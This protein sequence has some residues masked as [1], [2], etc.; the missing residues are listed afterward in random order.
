MRKNLF[1]SDPGE[2]I[3]HL[4]LRDISDNDLNGALI[5][6][7]EEQVL[8]E[9]VFTVEVVQENQEDSLMEVPETEERDINPNVVKKRKRTYIAPDKTPPR[10]RLVTPANWKRTKAKVA[11]N[12]GLAHTSKKGIPKRARCL[13]PP[14]KET[15]R[16]LCFSRVSPELR[17]KLFDKYWT[18]NQDKT[19]QWLFLAKLIRIVP[20]K[21]RKV[22]IHEDEEPWRKH[23][24]EY[25][26]KDLETEEDL[27]SVCQ[28]MFLNTFDVSTKVIKTA[29]MK[30]SPDKRGRHSKHKK[31]CPEIVQSVKDHIKK[32]PLVQS[33]YCRAD[34]QK[35]YLDENLSVAKM[36]RMYLMDGEEGAPK[37]SERNYRDIFNT[38]F[39]LS[40][41]KPKKDQCSLCTGFDAPNAVN[42]QEKIMEYNKHREE[43]QKVRKLK[44]EDK[45]LS[46]EE[47]NSNIR[48]VTFDLQKILY[49]PK[50]EIAEFYYKRKL[51]SFNSTLFDCTVKQGYCYVW[52]LTIGKKGAD[53]VA[54]FLYDYIKTMVEKGINDF[55]LYSDSCTGQNKNRFL[56]S[57]YYFAAMKF[58][59]KI[60]HRWLVKGHTQ[61]ECDNVHARIEKKTKKLDIY[62]PSQWYGSIRTAKVKKPQYIVKEVN[63]DIDIL[64]FRPLDE[65]FSWN[66]VPIMKL[67]SLTVDFNDPQN[68]S[69]QNEC[70]GPVTK[71]SILKRKVGRP[72]NW[73][74]LK[75]NKAYS[76]KLPLKAKLVEDLKWFIKKGFIP[77]A[78]LDFFRYVIEDPAVATI[79]VDDE[80]DEEDDVPQ[81]ITPPPGGEIIWDEDSDDDDEPQD[82]DDPVGALAN[83]HVE[84]PASDE[85]VSDEE[86]DDDD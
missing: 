9:D 41:F 72:V 12:A 71:Y 24:Y 16:K 21:Q 57:M 10:K 3:E 76:G 6:P 56:F 50:G 52:D 36:Y 49:C 53:E 86:D 46:R 27:I 20:I 30:N 18:L 62:T 43:K 39:N 70:D 2:N 54:T 28:T 79:T 29:L 65:Y 44:M 11:Y 42:S 32:Y 22:N 63:K 40:F 14:C 19:A 58:K 60:T 69:C 61:M 59:I 83:V 26:L 45:L 47:D 78:H 5:L 55:R 68:V 84:A 66:K 37:A 38:C 73:A 31:L 85:E 23:T 1:P 77:D 8:M 67:R 25:Y 48:V 13:K 75:I 7:L 15:C 74:T 81:E 35:R 34:T 17:Q 51:S 4:D 82:V 33:H 64:T 80:E